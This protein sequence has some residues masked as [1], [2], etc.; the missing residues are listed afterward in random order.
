MTRGKVFQ[1]SLLMIAAGLVIGLVA[2]NAQK[3]NYPFAGQK[4]AKIE[5]QGLKNTDESDLKDILQDYDI[6]EGKIYQ[7]FPLNEAV[8][9]IILKTAVRYIKVDAEK[10]VGADTGIRLLFLCKERPK[11]KNIKFQGMDE[12]YDTELREAIPLKEG[13]I[14][15]EKFL[16]DS[17]QL[18]L[19][20]YQDE[21]LFLASLQIERILDAEKNTLDIIFKIDEGEKVKVQKIEISGAE[22]LRAKD[23]V[24]AMETSEDGFFTDGS[25]SKTKYETDRIKILDYMKK[26]GYRDAEIV[27]NVKDEVQ[28]VWLDRKKETRGLNI[29]I[30][31]KEG[32]KYFFN[33]YK[34][35][36]EETKDASGKPVPPVF[37][38][39]YLMTLMMLSTPGEVFD[40][41]KYRRDR[42]SISMMYAGKGHIFTR[43]IPTNTY[44]DKEVVIGKKKYAPGTLISISFVI[45]EG[46]VAKVENIIIKGNKKTKEKV[47]RR[48]ILI[49]P[50]EIFN[51]FKIQRSRERI[52][53][54]GFFKEVNLDAR[55]GSREPMMNLV[56]DVAEQPTGTISLGGGYGTQSGFSIFTE[57]AENNLRGNGQRLSGR[58]E[59]GPLRKQ[60]Q[61]S[62]SDPW[63][64][65]SMPISFYVS[66]YYLL[67][68]Y[69]VTSVA[70]GSNVDAEYDKS[71]LG[72]TIGF[73]YRFWV[74][75]GASIR[76]NVQRSTSLRATG[77]AADAV[78]QQ[79]ALGPQLRNSVTTT[80]YRDSRDNVFNTVN[81]LKTQMAYEIAGWWGDDHYTRFSPVAEYYFSPFHLPYLRNYPTVLMFRM[82]GDFTFKPLW[83][84]A[85]QRPDNYLV[86]L[87]DKLYVGG[88][89]TV[90]GWDFVDYNFSS[91]ELQKSWV[92]GGDHRILYGMEYRI[93]IEPS[94]LWFVG[95]VD[96]G[97]LWDAYPTSA[98]TVD[99]G[100]P[101]TRDNISMKHF[102]YSYGFGIRV[103]IPILPIRLYL[104]Q[105]VVYEGKDV[106]GNYHGYYGFKK[107]GELNFVFGIGD[108]RY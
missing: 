105:R 22:N 2:T 50:G 41:E 77:A 108:F 58:F 20:K 6:Q 36:I 88:V 86:E 31:V 5:F 65:D 91:M 25:F 32:K 102:V 12:L 49:K 53:N 57:V 13:E 93:P 72:G 83:E 1:I 35:S 33:S 52:Y 75:W 97:A 3:I 27:S 26:E 70:P 107:L 85:N 76:F 80:L 61:T 37:T 78:F 87:D 92:D 4:I 56:I 90:R 42:Q 43:V 69:P 103:Q 79:I 64:I 99:L 18:I 14:L 55:P 74:F 95:F 48:E 39:R 106:N 34:I 94:M 96:A 100:Q 9:Q 38:T 81:G 16:S 8:K 54:L 23:L 63:I 51:S 82:S 98:S 44:N 28:F 104:A 45:K 30:K 17:K 19:K 7:P 24:G 71:I 89:E 15:N 46:P 11:I 21:G 62:F 101:L 67:R 47:I 68:T 10:V 59:Y 66:A 84:K 60:I 40:E 29:H 73:G